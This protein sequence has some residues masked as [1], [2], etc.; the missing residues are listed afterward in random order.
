MIFSKL[1]P[2]CHCHLFYYH[3]VDHASFNFRYC[4]LSSDL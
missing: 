2:A 3:V 1:I 4:H